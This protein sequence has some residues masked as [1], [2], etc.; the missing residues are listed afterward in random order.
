MGGDGRRRSGEKV[1]DPLL[2]RLP[3]GSDREPSRTRLLKD[4]ARRGETAEGGP[5]P[6]L[7]SIDELRRT[8]VRGALQ[9]LGP[10]LITGASD[11]DPSGIAT[12]AQ[13][14]SQ[15]G[16]A[17]LW[18][19]LFTLP[20]M[21]AFQEL[22]ARIAL[23]TGVGLGTALRRKFP[24]LLVGPCILAV[25]VANTINIGADLS[26]VAAG[27]SML[28]GGRVPPLL[29]VLPAAAVVVAMQLFL[30]Y[31]TTFNIFKWLTLALFAY[32]VTGVMAHPGLLTVLGATLVPH[33]VPSGEFVL[34]LVA[35]LG[36]TISPYLF[37]WQ[38]SAEVD[39]MRAA[40][41]DS[42]ARRRGVRL[43]ELRAA[44]TDVFVG[45]LFSQLV[46]YFIILTSAAV[47]NAHG[48]T[49]VQTAADA[50]AALRPFLGPL[51]E[52]V[53]ALGLIGTGLLAVPI[54]SGSAAYAVKE[55]FGFKGALGTRPAYRPTFYG[56]IVLA[57]LAGV[58][59]DFLGVQPIRAL[60]LS[61]VVNGLVAPP[62]MVL[63]VLLG[64]DRRRMGRRRSGRLSRTL[65]WAATVA[66]W[67]AA[68]ALVATLPPVAGLV[69]PR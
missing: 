14:G 47:L 56:I 55:F 35:V 65:T 41:L 17:M 29:L 66:M 44:R 37:F 63:I 24:A 58:A 67:A 69:H 27:G 26:A 36:T 18:T 57:T 39:Q 23:Q 40:G 52:V 9:V 22:C 16:Y 43:G 49:D 12:Y 68:L 42:E 6:G 1:R 31:R 64:Q 4:R 50:A 45:M 54:L 61:A 46:M 21:A 8:G 53:F 25:L 7:S 30:S 62:L 59:F 3:V 10:G 15:F 5:G 38:A 11:D 33:V 20:L 48:K 51:A 32:V 19:P 2:R 34:A 60:F 13:V 28:T